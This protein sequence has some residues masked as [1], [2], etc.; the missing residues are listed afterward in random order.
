LI[1]LGVPPIWVYSHALLRALICF[2]SVRLSCSQ[3]LVASCVPFFTRGAPEHVP[4]TSRERERDVNL[5]DDD[6][7]VYAASFCLMHKTPNRPTLYGSY[8]SVQEQ[9]Y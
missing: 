6:M 1:L 3:S 2:A 7:A 4:L 5:S 8:T 9:N